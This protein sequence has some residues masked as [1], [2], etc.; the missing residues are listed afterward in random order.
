MCKMADDFDVATIDGG[1]DVLPLRAPI[2]QHLSFRSRPHATSEDWLRHKDRITQLYVTERK[3]LAG[4]EGSWKL[5]A[6][7]LHRESRQGVQVY[8]C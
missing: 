1:S 7:F 4:S 6:D 8:Q 5:N 3:T 2:I